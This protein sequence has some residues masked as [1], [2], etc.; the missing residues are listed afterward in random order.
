MMICKY[1]HNQ[2]DLHIN[3]CSQPYNQQ[4]SLTLCFTH[5]RS[6]KITC[7]TLFLALPK[8][9]RI[10]QK[11]VVGT[12]TETAIAPEKCWLADYCKKD[13]FRAELLDSGRAIGLSSWNVVTK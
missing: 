2:I 7:Q 10:K 8:E 3:W 4:S 12:I 6:C 1:I 11:L 9:L 5:L 13:Y